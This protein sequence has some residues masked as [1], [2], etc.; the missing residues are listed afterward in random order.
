MKKVLIVTYYWPPAG[1]PGVQRWLKFSKYLPEFGIQPII[2]KPKNPSYPILDFSLEVSP[3]VVV[4][5]KPIFE[6]YA[7]AN[8][9]SKDDT[10]TISSGIIKSKARQSWSEQLMLYIRGNFFIPDARNFWVK[11]SVDYLKEYVSNN[12]IDTI[13]TTGPPHSMHLIGKAL[14]QA[15][16]NLQWIADFRDPWTTIGYHS[17]LKLTVSSQVKHKALEK[18]VLDS[19]DQLI[20]T[21]SQTKGEFET[22]TKT[23]VEV[24]TNG[25]ED[26][27]MYVELSENFT[28][29][30]VGSL[31]NDRNPKVLWEV[32]AELIEEDLVF[33]DF[34]ELK[35]IGKVSDSVLE[36]AYQ[37]GLKKFVSIIG[38]LDHKDAVE[39]QESSQMLLLIEINKPENKSII[40][41]KIFEYLAS[42][43]PILAI[44]P[45]G[46]DVNQ[47][48]SET[49]SG[50]CF[51]YDEKTSLKSYVKEAFKAFL[52]GK[53]KSNTKN[54]DQY[55]RKNLTQKL[56]KLIK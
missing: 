18:E 42:R 15:N 8:F 34:F 40:P 23:P 31:L 24:I 5:E 1:G 12:Q 53:L 39:S 43:R 48:I 51:N 22:K 21:S 27:P 13:I 25:F 2:Y 38:Y 56:V 10:K 4:L 54:I 26:T 6:P 33:K 17:A 49:H 55:H 14:K 45:K 7:M 29:S 3:E 11:P 20:V 44:G 41:G 36:S 9:L 19:A 37:S 28:V 32:F 35:L 46:W 30:H 47:I 50:K 16:P 52:N